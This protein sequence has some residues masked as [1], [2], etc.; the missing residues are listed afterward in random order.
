MARA[1]VPVTVIAVAMN[2]GFD[3]ETIVALEQARVIR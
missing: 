3:P 1:Q 2:I